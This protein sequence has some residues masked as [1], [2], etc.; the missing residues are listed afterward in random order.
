MNKAKTDS[1]RLTIFFLSLIGIIAGVLLNN[2]EVLN[3][4]MDNVNPAFLPG[5]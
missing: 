4:L 5:F 2:G 1:V 3:D